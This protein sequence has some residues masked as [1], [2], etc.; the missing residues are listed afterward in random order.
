MSLP[1]PPPLL[2][3]PFFQISI[4][5]QSLILEFASANWLVAVVVNVDYGR[6]IKMLNRSLS[7]N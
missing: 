5:L 6:E 7:T 3:V 2:P 4:S 1:S